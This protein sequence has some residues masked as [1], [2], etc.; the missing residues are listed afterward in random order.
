MNYEPN[1]V[2]KAFIDT[3]EITPMLQYNN[4]LLKMLLLP[5]VNAIPD[6]KILKNLCTKTA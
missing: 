5:A 4:I 3:A 2:L 6:F 1:V